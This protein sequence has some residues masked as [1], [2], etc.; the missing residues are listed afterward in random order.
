MKRST[1]MKYKRQLVGK[2]C[3]VGRHPVAATVS[4]R[5]MA[6]LNAGCNRSDRR[7]LIQHAVAT[8]EL[9]WR[10]RVESC[11]TNP[12]GNNLGFGASAAQGDPAA[13][14]LLPWSVTRGIIGTPYPFLFP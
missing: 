4:R 10:L 3:S 14:G 12:F 1:K 5:H 9:G 6:S 13:A 11:L 8:P 2:D 7:D